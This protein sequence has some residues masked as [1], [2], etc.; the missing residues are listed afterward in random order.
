[1]RRMVLGVVWLIGL[2]IV[3][4]SWGMML[5]RADGEGPTQIIGSK[6]YG[7]DS[8]QF[9]I[10]N[11]EN[12]THRPFVNGLS[13]GCRVIGWTADGE[14]LYYRYIANLALPD[15]TYR[16]ERIDATFRNPEIVVEKLINPTDGTIFL[17]EDT[18]HLVF[19][20]PETYGDTPKWYIQSVDD[21][22]QLNL[23]ASPP[24]G[25]E[26]QPIPSPILSPNQQAMIVPVRFTGDHSDY[27]YR[28][29]LDGSGSQHIPYYRGHKTSL[30][31]WTDVPEWLLVANAEGSANLTCWNLCKVRPD[32]SEVTILLQNERGFV[33]TGWFHQSG[34]VGI[35]KDD[36]FKAMWVDTGE[37]LWELRGVKTI[38]TEYSTVS[39]GYPW[40]PI[41]GTLDND[42]VHFTMADGRLAR[43]RFD[44]SELSFYDLNPLPVLSVWD[45]S[46]D[47]E[48]TWLETGAAGAYFGDLVRVQR[49][50][51]RIELISDRVTFKFTGWSPD[52]EWAYHYEVVSDFA[53][54]RTRTDGTG[55]QE[56]IIR[57]SDVYPVTW[58]PP[59]EAK[60]QPARTLIIGNGLMSVSILLSIVLW[61]RK[62]RWGGELKH[63]RG[64]RATNNFE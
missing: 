24:A 33:Y 64:I 2:L 27:L 17:T 52:G 34:I 41:Q 25:G 51:G 61:R 5:Q 23:I 9:E 39:T 10:I 37:I 43:C 30:V 7:Y 13:L 1:M 22:S 8:C 18:R 45:W 59:Y 31:A 14:W 55:K 62:K 57:D 53:L 50:T 63:A 44:G 49:N 29:N 26:F 11:P 21:P 4:S 3:V 60:W 54:R 20:N 12:G 38:F 46:P 47:G 58:T 16:I 6:S 56:V 32:G 40:R 28:V 35:Q 15:V 19:L 48:W 42:W 36:V